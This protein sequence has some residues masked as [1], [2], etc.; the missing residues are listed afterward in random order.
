MKFF[1][2]S[3]ISDVQEVRAK[4][5]FQTSR[6]VLL[7]HGL[8]FVVAHELA[9]HVLGHVD[10]P[11][12]SLEDQREMERAADA[13]AVKLVTRAGYNPMAAAAFMGLLSSLEGTSDAWVES[14]HPRAVCRQAEFMVKGHSTL[15]SDS[16][17]MKFL[18]EN[19]TELSNFRKFEA[20]V[21]GM[22]KIYEVCCSSADTDPQQC[23][24][25]TVSAG[26]DLSYCV[27]L[28]RI[29]NSSS[30]EFEGVRGEKKA[31]TDKERW[32]GLEILPGSSGCNIR[33]TSG[34]KRYVC[35]I[36]YLDSSSE[37]QSEY[38]RQVGSVQSCSGFLELNW[39]LV[40]H[41]DDPSGEHSTLFLPDSDVYGSIKVQKL[42]IGSGKY[43][44][45]MTFRQH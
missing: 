5:N 24:L 19:Q 16:E 35:E 41:Q 29:L 15:S 11:A 27:S 9:H 10:S 22:K 45:R 32:T 34:T 38:E 26:Y 8:A 43:F 36:G 13:Y 23:N 6:S 28:S 3:D 31:D 12:T 33:S 20:L 21:P 2:I 39:E 4:P 14:N 30:A 42:G 17:Y 37:W 40:T 1:R 25:T 7:T 18:D 44:I